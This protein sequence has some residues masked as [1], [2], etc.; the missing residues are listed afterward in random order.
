MNGT[1]VRGAGGGDSHSSPPNLTGMGRAERIRALRSQMSAMGAA[2]PQ[3]R[4][5]T[6][7]AQLKIPPKESVVPV[8]DIFSGFL[9]GGGLPRRSVTLVQDQ[10]LLVAELLSHVTARGGYAA[11]I[12]WKEFSYAG[13]IAAGGVHGNIIAIP[14]PGAEP[15]SVVAL[16]CEGLDLVIYRGLDITLS[17][18]RARPLLGRLRKGTAT[19]LMVGTRVQSPAVTLEAD[20]INYL[21]IGSGEGRIRGVEMRIRVTAKGQAPASGT[22][23]IGEPGESEPLPG[24][25]KRTTLRVV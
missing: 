1:H 17:P 10:P 23:V 18:V 6:E 3:L 8:P 2:V 24:Q 13:V 15:L 25:K 21:G 20:I 22:V 5:E 9:P 19:L 12:G 14:D 16:L 4:E 7:Q 11:M